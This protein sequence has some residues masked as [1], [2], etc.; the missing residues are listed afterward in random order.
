MRRLFVMAVSIVM[1]SLLAACGTTSG[2]SDKPVEVKVTAG[3]YYF[4]SSIT[5]FKQGVTYHFVVTNEGSME[6]EFMIIAP[7][8]STTGAEELDTAAL[9]H[10]EESDLQPGQTATVD[11]TFTQAYSADTL[12]FACHL[13][14][15]YE[16]GM[17]L[18]ITVK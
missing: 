2:S 6:H 15:H 16:L 11:Y 12:E 7:M 9:A 17:R 3:D 14:G 13:P 1:L 8:S 10:I 4:K 5:D 18:G